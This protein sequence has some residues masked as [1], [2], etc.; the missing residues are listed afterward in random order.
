MRVVD[1]FPSKLE[2]FARLVEDDSPPSSDDGYMDCDQ[3][4]LS[5]EKWEW[6]FC[7][8]VEDATVPRSTH[9]QDY[10]KLMFGSDATY[11]LKVDP[12]K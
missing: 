11:L 7:L 4:D 3:P 1:F 6:R 9:H 10:L 8:L 5:R 2:D 12:T